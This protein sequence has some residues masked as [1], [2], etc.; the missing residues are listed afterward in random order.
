MLKEEGKEGRKKRSRKEVGYRNVQKKIK[1]SI[2]FEVEKYISI[3]NRADTAVWQLAL[4]IVAAQTAEYWMSNKHKEKVINYININYLLKQIV[5]R[6][7]M[8][9]A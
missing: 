2:K 8:I 3:Y 4:R 5:L 7:P 1:M 9:Y 6:M